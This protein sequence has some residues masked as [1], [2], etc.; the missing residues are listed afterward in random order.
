MPAQLEC[1]HGAGGALIGVLAHAPQEG[2]VILAA[3]GHHIG[4]G[5]VPGHSQDRVCR[6]R[7]GEAW[8]A[9]GWG[10]AC[11][12]LRRVACGVAAGRQAGLLAAAAALSSGY[13]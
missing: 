12:C 3:G 5:G 1:V 4:A 6:A 8:C 9:A 13:G 11:G 10:P 2:P 7:R